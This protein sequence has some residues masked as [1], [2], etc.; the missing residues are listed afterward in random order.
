[1]VPP[2]FTAAIRRALIAPVTGGNPVRPTGG[3][4]A[5]VPPDGSWAMFPQRLSQGLTPAVPSLRISSRGYFSS[6]CHVCASVVSLLH[7]LPEAKCEITDNHTRKF[8][9]CQA[10][11][12]TNP[13]R[14][15]RSLFLSR[16]GIADQPGDVWN[17]PRVFMTILSGL[18]KNPR[19]F[20]R[21]ARHFPRAAL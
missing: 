18:P 1:M 6:H 19:F 16:Y 5:P 17:N 11:F 12:L 2:N 21:M 10:A 20:S 8:F 14:P 13:A 4:P 15:L 3:A 7:T 9:F